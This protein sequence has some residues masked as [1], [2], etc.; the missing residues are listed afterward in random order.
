MVFSNVILSELA[1]K[2]ITLVAVG[3][4]IRRVPS[5]TVIYLGLFI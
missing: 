3:S 1:E 5:P 4:T 2:Q